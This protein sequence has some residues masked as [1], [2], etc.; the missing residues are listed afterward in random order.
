M[1]NSDNLGRCDAKIAACFYG[2]P[3]P[4]CP[5]TK[6]VVCLQIETAWSL[7]FAEARKTGNRFLFE[8]GWMGS[9]NQINTTRLASRINAS[10]KYIFRRTQ[11]LQMPWPDR[12]RNRAQEVEPVPTSPVPC[13]IYAVYRKQSPRTFE[14]TEQTSIASQ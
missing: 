8:A 12:G 6:D 4:A 10:T 1:H 3:F 14:R 5:S 13:V 9:S 2:C 7:C 11:S